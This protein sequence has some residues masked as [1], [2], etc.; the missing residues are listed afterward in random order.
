MQ[1]KANRTPYVS[2][3]GLC[4]KPTSLEEVSGFRFSCKMAYSSYFEFTAARK[5][6]CE[7]RGR[8]TTGSQEYSLGKRCSVC[9]YPRPAGHEAV[10]FGQN[11]GLA[12]LIVFAP[13]AHPHTL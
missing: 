7:A 2:N 11:C 5:P 13:R 9:G 4:W 8:H 12:R 3:I 10:H 6:L 1:P